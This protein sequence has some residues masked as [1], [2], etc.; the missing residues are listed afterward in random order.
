MDVL[1]LVVGIGLVSFLMFYFAGQLEKEHGV[2]KFLTIMFALTL[3][4][5]V[6][7]AVVN[8]EQ[9]DYY[10]IQM[11]STYQYGNNFTGYHWDYDTGTTPDGPQT[12]AYLFH[13]WDDY[14][15]EEL[16][17]TSDNSTNTTFFKIVMWFYRLFMLYIILYL[18]YNALM[19]LKDS[20]KARG[21]K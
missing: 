9:C 5:I 14:Y 1:A 7:S 8:E 6:P 10:L 19:A 18:G 4:I 12:D 11:N 16:C 2:L 21:R 17:V 13:K 20:Y 3:L 15:Y